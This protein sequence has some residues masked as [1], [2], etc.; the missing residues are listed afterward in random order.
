MKV[1]TI[2]DYC[3]IDAGSVIEV[4]KETKTHYKGLW[5]SMMGTFKVTIPKDICKPYVKIPTI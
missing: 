3:N 1:K 4:T 5:S 2:K